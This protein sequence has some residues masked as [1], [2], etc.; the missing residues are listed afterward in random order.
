[1]TKKTGVFF[2]AT[3][4]LSAL[5]HLAGELRNIP[6]SCD[7]SKQPESGSLNWAIFLSFKDGVEWVFLSPRKCHDISPETT[8]KLLERV[9]TM[10]YIKLKSSI[11]VPEVFDYRYVIGIHTKPSIL[12]IIKAILNLIRSESLLFL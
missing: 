6:C 9:A 4:D 12:I 1:M 8:A 5:L 10:K 2:Y 7:S 11:P 3:F